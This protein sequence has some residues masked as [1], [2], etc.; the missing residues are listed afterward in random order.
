MSSLSRAVAI[1]RVLARNAPAG[2]G[3]HELAR[4]TGLPPSSV[5]RLLKELATH[6]LVYQD[7]DLRRYHVGLA[8]VELAAEALDGSAVRRQVH[9]HLVRLSDELGTNCF[10]T[11]LFQDRCICV[12]N[13]GPSG[14]YHYFAAVGRELPLNASAAAKSI[15]AFQTEPV[16][17][18]LVERCP[19]RRY[20]ASTVT[21][22]EELYRELEEIRRMGYAVCDED[23]EVGVKAIS[24]PLPTG[25]GQ[26]TASLTAVGPTA[27]LREERAVVQALQ[28][29]V[30]QVRAGGSQG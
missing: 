16:R 15:V 27:R 7:P 18:R 28:T 26:V 20:T 25:N 3:V 13:V 23:L 17:R 24:V 10:L 4:Q 14:S 19:M 2:I 30:E 21:D 29:A 22:R 12:D 5:H 9:P 8:V 1:L 11:L 6:G